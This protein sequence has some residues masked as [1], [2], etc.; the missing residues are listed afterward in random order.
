[1]ANVHKIQGG[2]VVQTWIDDT[3]ENVSVRYG[4]NASDLAAT[5]DPSVAAGSSYD[6]TKFG[7]AVR[8]VETQL[9]RL[10]RQAARLLA[11]SDWVD[12]DSERAKMSAGERNQWDQYR[13]DLR[14]IPETPE[15]LGGRD[16]KS[17]S[18]PSEPPSRGG[19]KKR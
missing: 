6:G 15:E 14:D 19:V 16:I 8:S 1:M 11:L 18:L 4:E 17:I 12:F 7:P 13:E 10:S 5:A 3:V 9:G 2:V